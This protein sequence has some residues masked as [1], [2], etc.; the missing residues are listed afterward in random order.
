[1]LEEMINM[2]TVRSLICVEFGVRNIRVERWRLG[3]GL[4]QTL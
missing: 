1:M 2:Y 4:D 3:I